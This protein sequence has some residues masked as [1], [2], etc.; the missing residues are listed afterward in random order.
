MVAP[1]QAPADADAVEGLLSS[2]SFLR[3]SGFVDDPDPE[4]EAGF[5]PPQF[6]VELEMSREA[7][8]SDPE[9]ARFAVGG[10]DDIG[11]NR[12]VRGAAESIYTI[13]DESFGN[14]PRRVVDYRDRRLA[15]FAVDDVRRVELGFHAATGETVAV[16]VTREEG[17]WVSNADPVLSEKLDALVDAL[18]DLRADD[19]IA[20]AF[21]PAELQAMELDPAKAVLLVYG[22]GDPAER[23]AEIHLGVTFGGGVTARTPERE[24][25]FL[26]D[27]ALADAIPTDLEAYRE[28]FV[29]QPES[30]SDESEAIA[31]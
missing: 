13:S 14:F 30:T 4:E 17:G 9:I 15:D 2:L 3:A 20:E 16:S 11:S 24:T 28:R 21:G 31:E 26:I 5:V 25:V 1:V 22:D 6:A 19:I 10:V 29:A 7:E 27:A 8:G 23:L 18:S 12:F